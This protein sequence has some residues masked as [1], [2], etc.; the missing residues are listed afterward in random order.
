VLTKIFD[1]AHPEGERKRGG[2]D[3]RGGRV[4]E[5]REASEKV[6]GARVTLDGGTAYV[7]KKKR[8]NRGSITHDSLTGF[9]KGGGGAV[10]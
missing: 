1:G 4:R 9:N 3:R 6:L 2:G 10:R 8:Q 5:A 7:K